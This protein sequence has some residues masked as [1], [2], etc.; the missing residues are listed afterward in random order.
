MSIAITNLRLAL[1]ATLSS[2]LLIGLVSGCGS[3]EFPVAPATGTI[4]TAD[5]TP[6]PSGT[7]TFTPITSNTEGLTGKPA[8]GNITNGEFS[9]SIQ[10]RAGAIVGSH[11]VTLTEAW[12]PDEQDREGRGPLPE[13][14]G[15]ELSPEWETL[16]VVAGKTNEYELIAIPKKRDPRVRDEEDD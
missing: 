5:G 13:K 2:V 4:K 7:L 10:G 6:L 14:H 8:Y 3:G 16:E 15:C 12:R 1:L 9:M 11:K